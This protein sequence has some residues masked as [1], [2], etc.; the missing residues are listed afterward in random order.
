MTLKKEKLRVYYDASCYLCSY[1]IEY[2]R[3]RTQDESIVFVDI[4]H[5]D[6]DVIQEGVSKVD[7]NKYFHVRLSNGNLISGVDAFVAI[8]KELNIFK[9]LVFLSKNPLLKFFM[10]A[11][12]LLFVFVRPFL[13]KK[14]QC[15]NGQCGDR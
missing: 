6:F 3:K 11:S 5:P 7:V 15:D 14:R 1:E 13:P 9:L 4:S 2:Y 12:Y 10:D 8:W